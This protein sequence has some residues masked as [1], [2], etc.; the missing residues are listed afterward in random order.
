MGIGEASQLLMSEKEIK[1][2]G[3]SIIHHSRIGVCPLWTNIEK[4][5]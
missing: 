1:K 3:K 2:F 4:C 5:R